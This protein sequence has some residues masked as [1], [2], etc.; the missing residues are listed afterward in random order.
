MD[1]MNLTADIN[2]SLLKSVD[3][4]L[5]PIAISSQPVKTV[6]MEKTANVQGLS[7]L[8]GAPWQGLILKFYINSRLVP[9]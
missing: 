2:S 6:N 4:K 8:G 7:A 3:I 9:E 1:F 5:K